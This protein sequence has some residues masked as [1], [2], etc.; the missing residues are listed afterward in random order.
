V[1]YFQWFDRASP[2]MVGDNIHVLNPG[3]VTA[4][5]SV[6]L[7]AT[8]IPMTLAPGQEGHVTFPKGK[9]G[10][11]VKVSADVNVLAWQRVQYYQSFNEVASATPA[12]ALTTSYIM[13][14]DRATPG[15]VG[16]N[17][18]V[19][20][21]GTTAATVTV[22]LAGILQVTVTVA[23]GAEAHL[24]FPAGKIGGPITITSDQP[25]LGA[26]RVQYYQSFNEVPSD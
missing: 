9:I 15:M 11:P 24:T 4:H 1:S 23:P 25:V 18:H 19:L 14:F 16:D 17:V 7:G 21:P 22:N 2:G 3:A 12:Q 5:V 20:N 10:G 6:S 13:W 8:S 26:Q